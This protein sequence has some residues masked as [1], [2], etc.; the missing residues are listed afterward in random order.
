MPTGNG[1]NEEALVHATGQPNGQKAK[2]V[3]LLRRYQEL[4][5]LSLAELGKASG[6]AWVTLSRLFGGNLAEVS[7]DKLL[8]IFANLGTHIEIRVDLN[9]QA[10][11]AGRVDVRA[12]AEA[13]RTNRAI[14]PEC[15]GPDG[16]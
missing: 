10:N 16:R 4:N 8:R 1:F 2:L 9:P 7:T 5:G 3:I 6:V 13:A 12:I 14:P 15:D 11:G